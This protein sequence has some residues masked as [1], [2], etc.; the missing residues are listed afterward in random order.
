MTK[1]PVIGLVV[2]AARNCCLERVQQVCCWSYSYQLLLISK[3]SYY[4][5]TKLAAIGTEGGAGEC[6]RGSLSGI[7]FA[8]SADHHERNNII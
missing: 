3:N 4:T 8:Q 1:K 2:V 7:S 5:A 6:G